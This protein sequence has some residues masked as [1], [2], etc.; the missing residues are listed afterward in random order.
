MTAKGQYQVIDLE[1]LKEPPDNPR[2]HVDPKKLEEL[3][4][5][6]KL[7]GVLEPILVR[8]E[9]SGYEIVA[10]WRRYR[11]SKAAGL[12][13]IPA[14]VRAMDDREAVEVQNIENLQREDI[15]PL[16]EGFAYRRLIEKAGYD[17]KTLAAKL[18]KPPVYILG[19]LKL[20]DLIP[21]A[22]K[23]LLG[24]HLTAAAGFALARLQPETQ[25]TVLRWAVERDDTAI[26]TTEQAIKAG[27]VEIRSAAAI[28]R[29]IHTEI[30]LDLHSA[31]WKKDD[32]T[33]YPQA[34]PCT[35]CPKRSGN[36]PELFPG[37][38]GDTCTDPGCFAMKFNLFI[39]RTRKELA[40]ADKRAP[41][42]VSAEWYDRGL[43]AGTIPGSGWH[44]AKPGECAY[45]RHA[46]VVGEGYNDRSLKRGQVITVCAEQKCKTH[47][48]GRTSSSG[49]RKTPTQAAAEKRARAKRDLERQVRLQLVSKVQEKVKWPLPLADL[50]LV[51]TQYFGDV[52]H[53]ARKIICVKMGLQPVKQQYGT[54]YDGPVE[55]AIKAWDEPKLARF[56]I[57][58]AV[59]RDMV[60]PRYEHSI[61]KADLLYGVAKRYGVD[62]EKVR[63]Q[64]AAAKTTKAKAKLPKPTR[65][66][67]K[68][69]TR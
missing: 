65:A 33:L 16:D 28:E 39:E 4:E 68:K 26:G 55:R 40:E 6:I 42:I 30:A 25:K 50:R 24:G 13:T 17:V 8:P 54:D 63:G 49:T 15:H 12:T 61:D 18:H 69:A 60:M 7:R 32:A 23:L 56:L 45:A 43:P 34:G 48:A 1:K 22:Q 31:P 10:G 66:V 53:D 38:K 64:L 37:M 41:L 36:A 62:A 11:A 51:A 19:R 47:W 20:T 35:T 9:N 57:M 67:R 46:V 14:I 29:Y 44:K 2:Q 21:E 58:L 59:A 5:S 3:T 52:W 27:R